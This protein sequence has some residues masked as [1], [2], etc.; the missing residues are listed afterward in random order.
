[1]GNIPQKTLSP[2]CAICGRGLS[3]PGIPV[4]GVG[5]VGPDCHRKVAAL[6][7]LLEAAGL[8][9]LMHGPVVLEAEPIG[10]AYRIPRAALQIKGRAEKAG[11]YVRFATMPPAQDGELPRV[12]VSLQPHVS[13]AG[14]E[15]LLSSLASASGSYEEF[16]LQLRLRSLERQEA[17]Q[18]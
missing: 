12:E 15:R 7:K 10:D 18:W 13:R 17:E 4:P 2:R 6:P 14:R 5:T 11:L 9:E 16:A 8:A 1:M 3:H